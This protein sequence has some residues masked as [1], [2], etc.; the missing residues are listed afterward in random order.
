MTKQTNQ[1]LQLSFVFAGDTL[2][3][4]E[5]KCGTTKTLFHKGLSQPVDSESAIEPDDS[6][7]D[8]YPYTHELLECFA[9]EQLPEQLQAVSK[10]FH[11]LAHNLSTMVKPGFQR[12]WA[13]QYLLIAKDAA[14]RAALCTAVVYLSQVL[15]YMDGI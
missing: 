2:T 7:P 5:A 15:P 12:N 9:Y 3:V 4:V 11:D 1:D 14:V 8:T 13:L 10:P 6:K